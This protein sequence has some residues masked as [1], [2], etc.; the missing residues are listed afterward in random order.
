MKCGLCQPHCPTY[1]VSRSEAESPRGRI[2]LAKALAQGA[3]DESSTA[4]QHLDQCLACLRCECVC[5]SQ[6]LYGELIVATR[7]LLQ[8]RTRVSGIWSFLARHPFLLR[9]AVRACGARS[10][11]RL[12]QS[13]ALRRFWRALG[14]QR[15][16]DELPTL[17]PVRDAR[18]PASMASRGR[19]GLLLG[20][21][22]SVADRDVQAAARRLLTA[23]GY[24]VTTSHT[25][26]CCGALAL[27]AGHVG[28]AASL[29]TETLRHAG[30]NGVATVL[31]SASGCFGTLRDHV[32]RD[33]AL[34]VR[35]I[36]EFLAADEG[37]QHLTFRALPRRIVLHTPCSQATV[38]RADGAIRALLQR[39]PQMEIV[40]LPSAPGC[41][42]AAGDYFL[43]HA[44]ISDAL[45]EQTLA[46]VADSAGELLITSNVGCRIFLGNELRRRGAAL[47]IMHPVALLAQQLEN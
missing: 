41:C 26:D 27:H 16:I 20:C 44:A 45:R 31:V 10:V 4:A 17:P 35:E 36:H 30:T 46:H 47:P 13:A 9:A 32:P 25:G 34:R 24:E 43:R 33:G 7:Q 2:A 8:S 6:V 40:D 5:P 15:A 19:V 28:R 29:A 37:L 3:L 38:A 22:A 1:R 42:G 39:I 11:R 23:L 21:V 14:M 18:A 12:L